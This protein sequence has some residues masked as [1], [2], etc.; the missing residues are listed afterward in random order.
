LS[1]IELNK[2]ALEQ[3]KI[4]SPIIK[5]TAQAAVRGAGTTS[6]KDYCGSQSLDMIVHELVENIT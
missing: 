6:R 3:K 2:K 4:S 1:Q 5:N